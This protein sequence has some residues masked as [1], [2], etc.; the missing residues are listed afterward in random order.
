ML[1]GT[2]LVKQ[3]KREVR[4]R[5]VQESW[6]EKHLGNKKYEKGKSFICYSILAFC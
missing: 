3:N 1:C 4:K 2:N 5:K 6:V